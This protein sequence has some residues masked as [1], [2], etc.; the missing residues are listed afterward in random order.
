MKVID[1]GQWNIYKPEPGQFPTAPR[2]TLFSR[3]ESDGV[4]W[5]QYSHPTEDDRKRNRL[6]SQNF[7]EDSVK[8]AIMWHEFEQQW[9]IGASSTDVS[10]IF[11]QQGMHV[12][13]IIGFGST[14]ED[15]IIAHFRNMVVDIETTEIVCHRDKFAPKS[16]M[17]DMM[18]T[19]KD[20]I[21]RL[22]RLEAKQ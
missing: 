10:L 22:E 2:G 9:I 6:F 4:D 3:R 1:H 7:Q 17:L 12:R 13:E 20:V 18:D 19:L 16:P 21:A 5:Y 15:K 14:D 11:P 8:V